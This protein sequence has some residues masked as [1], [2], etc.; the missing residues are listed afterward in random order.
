[1]APRNRS[2]G[3]LLM[4]LLLLGCS[5][6]PTGRQLTTDALTAMGGTEKLKEIRTVVMKGEGTRM[7]IGQTLK[8]GDPETP[9]TLRTVVEILDLANNLASLDYEIQEGDFMQHRHEI[10]TVRGAANKPVGIEIVGTRPVV[11]TSVGGLF[12]WGTQNSPEISLRRNVV[13]IMLAASDT[14]DDSQPAADK[15]LNGKTYKYAT[16]KTKSGEDLGLYFDPQSK[17]LAAF[18]VMDTETMLGD[19]NAVYILDDYKP[20]DG[21]LLPHR[22]NIQKGGTDYSTVQYVSIAINAPGIGQVF[23][24]PETAMAEADKAIAAGEYTPLKLTKVATGVYHAQAYSHHSMIVEFPN[25]LVVVE[26]PYTETQ[27]KVL[28]RLLQ[29]QFPGKPVQYAV[30][31]HHHYDHT[32]GVRGIAALGA[33]VLVERGHE[34][35]L[36]EILDARH[37]HPQDDLDR[38]RSAEPAGRTGT[39]EVYEGRKVIS[40]G[41]QS[42]ELY[43][44]TGSSHVEPMVLVYVPSARVLFQSD[45]FFPG[46]GGGGPL[47]E[48]LLASIRQLNLR[49]DTLVGGHGG[50]GPFAELV[51]AAAPKPSSD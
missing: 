7:R 35:V 26:A 27:S 15:T 43:P 33:T 14:A 51:K 37:T 11:A 34:A 1:M 25:W 29:E 44:V 47:A 20:V 40:D 10:L 42:V 22:V 17:L 49:V 12:S 16:A 5:S 3:I 13:A 4:S 31:T 19:V 50:V 6:A 23:A 18:D 8:A 41:G 46:T 30:V 28:A 48:H 36:R 24:I 39:M 9:A 45:L 38:L 32:G 2:I 21:V